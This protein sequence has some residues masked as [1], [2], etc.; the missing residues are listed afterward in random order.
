MVRQP[1]RRSI[2]NLKSSGWQAGRFTGRTLDKTTTGL[3]RWL[4]TDH[5]GMARMLTLM[6]Q[7]G[8]LDSVKYVLACLLITL[9]GIVLQVVWLYFLIFHGL[10]LLLPV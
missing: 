2:R 1:R 7:M 3:F 6:P 5:S 8:L 9:V 4:T 10:P